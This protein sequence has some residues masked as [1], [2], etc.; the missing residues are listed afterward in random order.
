M[1]APASAALLEALALQRAPRSRRPGPSQRLPEGTLQ[2]VRLAAGEDEATALA[3]RATGENPQ[4]LRE[5]AI[6][7][8]QQVFF[9][10]G[11]S[12]YRVLGAEPDFSDE[13]LREHYRWLARWLHP[14]RNPDEWEVVF[15]ER[16]NNAWQD[17][18][19]SERRARYQP[20]TQEADEWSSAV[21]A[22][23]SHVFQAHEEPAS[24]P[25][26]HHD[27][28]WVPSAVIATLGSAAI[29][30]IVLFYSS[31]RPEAPAISVAA[32]ES[33]ELPALL[34]AVAPREAA[35]APSPATAPSPAGWVTPAAPELGI[36]AEPEV[37]P[38]E[39]P[40]AVRLPIPP[41]VRV[42]Q[43]PPARPAVAV[44]PL[45]SKPAPRPVAAAAKEPVVPTAPKPRQPPVPVAAAEVVATAPPELVRS[46]ATP[47]PQIVDTARVDL[48]KPTSRDANR[49]L[50]QLS[51]AYEAG[52]VDGMRALFAADASG[53]KGN[54]DSILAEYRR[55]FADSSERSLA[56]RDVSWF[57]NGD[58]FT[59]VAT[60]EANVTDAR[61][62]RVRKTRGDLRL[63]LRREGDHWQIF[64]MQHGERPG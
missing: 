13:R 26:A 9:A 5:A 62:G 54:L 40:D 55:V 31:Q 52:D 37:A 57:L 48:A 21:A 47:A 58:T 18:R 14:D 2:L 7:Y 38:G 39:V 17:V 25:P 11:S 20:H 15:A 10:P 34:T 23:P 12:S 61:G 29:A 24:D 16:V 60:F 44:Q 46:V 42:A 53:P 27:L 43:A 8:I 4:T 32:T 33:P 35:P 28:R 51:R 22:P 36:A 41:P 63:D 49:L 30:V 6:F 1:T 3:Q 19:T 64:R 45:P 50:G 56:V 59:I